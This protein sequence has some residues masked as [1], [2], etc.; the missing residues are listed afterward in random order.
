MSFADPLLARS[1]VL[2][3]FEQIQ[4][5]LLLGAGFATLGLLG[6]AYLWL[7]RRRDPLLFWFTVFAFAY[8]VYLIAEY[9]LLWWLGLRP[10]VF[11]RLTVALGILLPLPAFFFF[12]AL[13]LL[14]R[15][16]RMLVFVI[17]GVA[18]GLA[19]A[20]LVIGPEFRIV[21]HIFVFAALVVFVIALLRAETR[22]P[23]RKVL[24]FGL[25]IFIA[26]SLYDHFTGLI[27]HYYIHIEPFSFVVLISCLGLL[28]GRHALAQEQELTNVQRELEIARQIQFSILPAAFP[29]SDSSFRVDVRYLPMTS[30]AGDFYDFLVADKTQA[31]ILEIGRASCRER[32]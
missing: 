17:S 5:Y 2:R 26:C 27:G 10:E 28:A 24:R 21:N 25:L 19:I 1:A 4:P 30:V 9:Q 7:R 22:T 18:V 32:V 13:D 15:I 29:S 23:G 3:S 14:G 12:D 20:T 31:G 16:G 8:G 6:G 11:R